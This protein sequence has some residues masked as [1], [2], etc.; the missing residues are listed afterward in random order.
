MTDKENNVEGRL[1]LDSILKDPRT[2][3]SQRDIFKYVV[4]P[5]S[6][7]KYIESLLSLEEIA[8]INL[9]FMLSNE[10]AN[11]LMKKGKANKLKDEKKNKHY[12]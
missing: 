5:N 12:N 10:N 1:F 2:D 11:A 6:K 4:Q 8:V 9:E 7:V 3:I